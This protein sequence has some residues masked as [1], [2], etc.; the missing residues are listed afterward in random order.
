MSHKVNTNSPPLEV[1]G[2]DSART[3][4]GTWQTEAWTAWLGK[5]GPTSGYY[6]GMQGTRGLPNKTHAGGRT[7]DLRLLIGWAQS[8]VN[9]LETHTLFTLED[10]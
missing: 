7:R 2:V 1:R 4:G 10:R 6:G 9:I 5:A 3:T 8:S